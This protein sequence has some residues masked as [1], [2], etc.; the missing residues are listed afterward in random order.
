MYV[1]QIRLVVGM[2]ILLI[3]VSLLIVLLQRLLLRGTSVFG[4]E[5]AAEGNN[6][7][8]FVVIAI[9]TALTLLGLGLVQAATAR[10]LVEV[11]RGRAIGPLRAYMLPRDSIRPL[12]GRSS[13]R[14]SWSRCS[15][16]LSTFCRSPSGWPGGGR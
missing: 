12:L 10:A 7:V 8:A 16:A 6:V 9:G 3:P 5:S 4:V 2:G 14:R 11:D 13:S 15:P 1:A